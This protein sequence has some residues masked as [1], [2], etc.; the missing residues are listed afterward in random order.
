MTD[1]DRRDELA[2][3]HRERQEAKRSTAE[4][5]SKRGVIVA[6]IVAIAVVVGGVAWAA[7]QM[8]GSGK[9][10]T[11]A[12]P[13]KSAAAPAISTPPTEPPAPTPTPVETDP[14]KIRCEYV[15]DTAGQVKKAE[16]PPAKPNLKARTMRLETTL[17]LVEVE[18]YTKKAPCTVNSFVSLAKQKFF[19]G[20]KCHRLTEAAVVGLGILQCGDPL[21]KADGSKTDG[22]GGP[23]YKFKDENLAG[24]TYPVGTLAMATVEPDTNGSQFFIVHAET[25]LDPLF[26]PFGKIVKGME[27]I[28]EVAEAGADTSVNSPT[29]A[30]P[31]K[32]PIGIK[33]VTITYEAGADRGTK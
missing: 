13:T 21:A 11:A 18:L 14:A 15:E 10:E 27:I 26:T 7:T 5:G 29:E 2:R 1:N 32:K 9:Q 31:P 24:A 33:K 23:G 30:T 28:Q 4:S 16:F 22:E 25:P 20:S 19:D 8:G 3:E 12:Q 17:G 6:V